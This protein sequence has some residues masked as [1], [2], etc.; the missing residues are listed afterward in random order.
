MTSF[1]G[2]GLLNV[3]QESVVRIA[4]MTVGY[5]EVWGRVLTS[6]TG[7]AL[8]DVPFPVSFTEEPFF[9]SGAVLGENFVYESGSYPTGTATLVKWSRWG[10]TENFRGYYNG[11]QLALIVTGL[12]E[13][14][15]WVNWIVKGKAF[16]NPTSGPANNPF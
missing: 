14:Q 16:T 9:S 10:Q 5:T 8:V 15:L 1:R 4:D 12:V 13:Q 11:A 6:G 2:K 7:E 3:R